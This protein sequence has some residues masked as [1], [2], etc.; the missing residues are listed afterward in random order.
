MSAKLIILF[1]SAANLDHYEQFTGGDLWEKDQ[2]SLTQSVVAQMTPHMLPILGPQADPSLFRLV[3]C[4]SA[5]CTRFEDGE[6]R[7][8]ETLQSEVESAHSANVARFHR[9]LQE[10]PRSPTTPSLT[11]SFISVSRR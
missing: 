6:C 7:G 9:L 5:G 10:T 4:A 1:A 11:V 8:C 3:D 2:R